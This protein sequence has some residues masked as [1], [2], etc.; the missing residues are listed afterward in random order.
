[1]DDSE[2]LLLHERVEPAG[3]LVEDHELGLSSK[4]WISP[5][6]SLLPFEIGDPAVELHVE[7]LRERLDALQAGALAPNRRDV[8]DYLV[9]P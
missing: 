7:A 6:F 3:G 2:H 8:L 9:V 5:I 4:P 1:M